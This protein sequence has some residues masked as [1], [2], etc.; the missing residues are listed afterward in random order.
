MTDTTPLVTENDTTPH[1]TTTDRPSDFGGQPVVSTDRGLVIPSLGFGTWQLD[2]DTAARMVQAALDMG[3]RHI[4]TA[5]MYRNESGV[6][7]GIAAADID[8]RDIFLTTKID[9]DAHEPD[10]LVSSVRRSLDQLHTDY[11]DLLL[12]HWPVDYHRI[13]ATMATLAQVQA[14]GLAHHIGVSNF[15]MDQLDEVKDMAPVEVLQVE[16]HPFFQ[17]R[18]LRRWCVDNDW[19]FTAYSPIAQGRVFEVDAWEQL[20]AAADLSPTQ[21]ALAWLL[22]QERVT[23]IPRTT[24]LEHLASNF[25][26]IDTTLDP[27]VVEA[28]AEFDSGLRLVDPDIAPWT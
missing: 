14:D 1:P 18:E 11:V 9:N 6:G 12:I 17:Q 16:C 22:D 4:D 2:V 28:I 21:L 26:A 5:Q 24:S 20:A 25:A 23:A 7:A 10:A 3:Y 15:T 8:R 27:E 19:A 13:S